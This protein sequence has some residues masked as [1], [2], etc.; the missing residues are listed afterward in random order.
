MRP[1]YTQTSEE[2]DR[3]IGEIRRAR[4]E[5]EDPLAICLLGIAIESLELE[6]AALSH[7]QPPSNPAPG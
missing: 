6:K 5:A 7:P 1:V 2:I 3:R 4:A